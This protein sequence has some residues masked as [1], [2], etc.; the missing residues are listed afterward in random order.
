MC[1]IWYIYIYDIN[2]WCNFVCAR[3][4]MLIPTCWI[5]FC[6]KLSMLMYCINKCFNNDRSSSTLW[7]VFALNIPHLGHDRPSNP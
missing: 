6:M 4:E 3:Y 2:V 5:Y 1:H 7:F